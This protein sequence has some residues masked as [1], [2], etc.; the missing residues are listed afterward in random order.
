MAHDLIVPAASPALPAL[1]AV[2]APVMDAGDVAARRYVE[3]FAANIRNPNTRAAYARATGDF[4]AWCD[5]HGLALAAVQPVHVAAWIEGLSQVGL[6]APSVKQRLAAVRMLFDWLVV[7]QVVPHNPAAPVRGPKHS[8]ARG[9]T[10]MPTREEAKALLAAIPTDSIVGLRDRAL[11]ATLL[12]TFA[13]VGAATAMRVADYYPVGKRWWVRLHEKGGKH[14]EMP[15]HHTL[16][17]YL[18]AY[19]AAAGIGADARAPLFRT[20]A[21]RADRLTA[22]AMRQPDVYRMIR[23][24][25]DAAGVATRIGCHSWRARGITAYLE[26]GGLLEHA[27]AMAGHASARTTKLY[28]RRGEQVSLDEVERITL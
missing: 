9:K 18:D 15:C 22:Q 24:R 5:R 19:I 6:S 23:R 25:A 10:R 16:Q 20:A 8:T 28:D 21:G 7:G 27:Q 12:Y 17:E 11:I 1:T 3:F 14:H 4:F 2:P 13:R 26:N